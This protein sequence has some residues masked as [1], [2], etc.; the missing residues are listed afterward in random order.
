MADELSFEER[1][2][3]YLYTTTTGNL[4]QAGPKAAFKAETIGKALYRCLL[5]KCITYRYCS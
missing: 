4:Y 1:L 3:R 2:T 5:I